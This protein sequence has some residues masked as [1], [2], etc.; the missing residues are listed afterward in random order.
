MQSLQGQYGRH[1]EISMKSTGKLLRYCINRIQAIV[2]GDMLT[3]AQ[4]FRFINFDSW[5]NQ[6]VVHTIYS[7]TVL[8]LIVGPVG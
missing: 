8:K 7:I 5:S 4:S 1:D 6:I 3:Q 2:I